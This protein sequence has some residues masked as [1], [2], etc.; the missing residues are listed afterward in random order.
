MGSTTTVPVVG[1]GGSAGS[2]EPL[3]RII[4][5]LPTESGLAFVGTIGELCIEI[6]DPRPMQ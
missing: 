1:I 3:Q 4:T 5:G 2:L 6:P